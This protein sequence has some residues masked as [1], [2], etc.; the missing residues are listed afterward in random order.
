[1][2]SLYQLIA[3]IPENDLLDGW[4]K[5]RSRFESSLIQSN[6]SQKE[7]LLELP[8]SFWQDLFT[9]LSQNSEGDFLALSTLKR[10]RKIINKFGEILIAAKLITEN[11][12]PTISFPQKHYRNEIIRLDRLRN[13]KTGEMSRLI[14]FDE[15]SEKLFKVIN[16]IEKSDGFINLMD[17]EE[18][19]LALCLFTG[20]TQTDPIK[21][22]HQLTWKDVRIPQSDL[23]WIPLLSRIK[24]RPI[25][26]IWFE[27]APITKLLFYCKYYVD[28]KKNVEDGERVFSKHSVEALRKK[29]KNLLH[30][31]CQK[32]TIPELS[33][34]KLVQLERFQMSLSLGSNLLTS[35]ISGIVPINPLQIDLASVTYREMK[36]GKPSNIEVVEDH[37]D[38]VT[39]EN[40]SSV[41]QEKEDESVNLYAE[42]LEILQ[43]MVSQFL[44]DPGN[45]KPDGLVFFVRDNIHSKNIQQRNISWLVN[46]I[47]EMK[48]L[49]KTRIPYWAAVLRV[50]AFF[51]RLSLEQFDQDYLEIF[52]D[53]DYAT[54][55]LALS[56]SAVRIFHSYLKDNNVDVPEINWKKI[57]I[58]RTYSTVA[59]ISYEDF[60]Q[61]I[62]SE[63][64]SELGWAVKMAFWAGLRI[65]EVC[66]VCVCDLDILEG[67]PLLYVV[68]S[69]RKKPRKV[70]L[71]HL[72]KEELMQL[73]KFRQHRVE[74]S[75]Q[76]ALLIVDSELN[77][78]K[79]K[80]TTTSI[81]GYLFKN[82]KYHS[83][84]R[85][86]QLR[87]AALDIFFVMSKDIRFATLLGGHDLVQT[88]A[89]YYQHK[90]DLYASIE[91]KKWNNPLFREDLH[92]PLTNLA[93]MLGYSTKHISNCINKFNLDKKHSII[94]RK[95]WQYLL[96]GKRP[97]AGGKPPLYINV[98]DA[99]RLV[100][101]MIENLYNHE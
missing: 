60:Q 42:L 12:V 62:Q 99:I 101:W 43:P 47:L 61:L 97:I 83:K 100:D 54:S 50:I 63:M 91:L 26:G 40:D 89:Q 70:S 88:N 92:I 49:K 10:N 65:G 72:S 24:D 19:L 58:T 17:L 32:L 76:N 55:S 96:D 2:I 85:F 8:S 9:E 6:L 86:H 33:V 69:K 87:A 48:Q 79:N 57:K 82:D 22:L 84:R 7:S 27:P 68:P 67:R 15:I 59:A 44:L 66:R 29:G 93:K 81:S 71:E 98:L 95:E 46:W 23:M 28:R 80:N 90:L 31:Y 11:S 53:S 39:S 18:T 52:M 78:L 73:R 45:D 5:A 77:G 14:D 74:I 20:F 41:L 16:G 56:K 94:R 75:G 37:K 34:Q 25:G 4:K 3:A 38:E 36:S 51:P 64:P 30:Q 21:V 1:M 35:V 13:T